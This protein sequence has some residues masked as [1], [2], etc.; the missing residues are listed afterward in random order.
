MKRGGLFLA[1]LPSAEWIEYVNRLETA[2]KL[3]ADPES[4]EVVTRS[5]SDW[6]EYNWQGDD[7]KEH[8]WEFAADALDYTPS[9]W[10]TLK[11]ELLANPETRAAYEQ[12]G[13]RDK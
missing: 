13:E 5:N 7:G 12:K 6:N 2:L 4:W 3:Y 9:D 11:E 1:D 10:A 8:A